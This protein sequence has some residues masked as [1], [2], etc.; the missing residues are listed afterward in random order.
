MIPHREALAWCAGFFDGEGN[1]CLTHGSLRSQIAQRDREVLD[2]I[3]QVLGIGRVQGP[4]LRKAEEAGRDQ[5]V[6]RPH[7]RLSLNTFEEVQAAVAMLW[8]WLGSVKRAQA[9]TALRGFLH[10]KQ[11]T[12]RPARKRKPA[13]RQ[14]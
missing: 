1:V 10:V 14:P 3:V 4:Y 6:R 9:A 13:Q 11:L 8:P 5:Y 7:F 12:K 2:R